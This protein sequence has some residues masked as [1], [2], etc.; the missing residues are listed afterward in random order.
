MKKGDSLVPRSINV[1]YTKITNLK[2][3][4]EKIHDN[5]KLEINI[6]HSKRRMDRFNENTKCLFHCIK[7][8]MF[9]KSFIKYFDFL[10]PFSF[11]IRINY[12]PSCI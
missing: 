4:Y 11:V 7:T 12:E 2:F 6:I 10:E 8:S 3:N 1:V 5:M 9:F